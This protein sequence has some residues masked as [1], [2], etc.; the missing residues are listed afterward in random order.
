VP[1]LEIVE[2]H[3]GEGLEGGAVEAE[4]ELV[5]G[6]AGQL[7]VPEKEDGLVEAYE[8]D[9]LLEVGLLLHPYFLEFLEIT[10]PGFQGQKDF[11]FMAIKN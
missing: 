8:P 4:Q 1:E 9:Q 5:Q 6:Q 7:E 2:D 3:A 11:L 10:Q